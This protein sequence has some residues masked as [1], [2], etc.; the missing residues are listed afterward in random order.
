[1]QLLDSNSFSKRI[2]DIYS[3]S[4][5]KYESKPA[6]IDFYSNGCANCLMI[7]PILNSLE[8]QYSEFIDFYKIESIENKDIASYFGIKSLPTILLIKPNS[9]LKAIGI[10]SEDYYKLIIDEYL[11]D[12]K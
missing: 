4:N 7:M 11:K 3:D 9:N 5:W 8:E 10:A 1:M 12:G 6:L 2:F